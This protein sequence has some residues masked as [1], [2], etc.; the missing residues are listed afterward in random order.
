MG[1]MPESLIERELENLREEN[2]RLR[3]LLSLL[4]DLS[5][6]I[7]SSLDLST[8]MQG[9]VDAACSLIGARFGALGVFDDAGHILEF[10]THGITQEERDQIGDLPQGLGLLGW[11]NDL[12][13]PLRLAD[14]SGHSRSVGFPANHPPMKT[15]LGAPLRYHNEKL[16][17]LYLTEKIAGTEFTPEDE[18]LL[19]LFSAQ[20][21]MAIHNARLHQR[22]EEESS[23]VEELAAE[24]GKLLET[25]EQGR[26]RL[27][28]L[29]DASPVG[30]FVV[31]ADSGQVVLV[32]PEAERI[33]GFSHRPNF[34]LEHYEQNTTC[35]RPDG[36]AYSPEELPLQRAL[37]RGESVRAEEVRFEF[38]DGHAVP[39][40]VNATPIYSDDGQVTGAIAVIQDITPLGEIEQLRNEFLGMVSLELRTPLTAIK[41][42]AATVLGS[43]THRPRGSV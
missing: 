5:L 35:R 32:N 17:N 11:L 20:A 28:A 4:G 43:R 24:R 42:S 1:L 37:Y 8:V 30:V 29:V 40:L 7:T 9:V 39:T 14:L 6:Q 38:P 31:E 21:A 18:S 22:V 15:F 26:R 3:N 33:L 27:Q 25:A 10:L 12:Q 36:S 16:G 41:G 13:Q 19:S 34:R 2:E 23:R